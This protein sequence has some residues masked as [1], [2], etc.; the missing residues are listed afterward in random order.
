VNASSSTTNTPIASLG[1]DVGSLNCHITRGANTTVV[2]SLVAAGPDDVLVCGQHAARIAA[3]APERVIGDLLARL[4][5]PHMARVGGRRIAPEELLA[6]LIDDVVSRSAGSDNRRAVQ[7]GF[8]YPSRFAEHHVALV[9]RAARL[10]GLERVL[11]TPRP[12][13]IARQLHVGAMSPTSTL[14]VDVGAQACELSIVDQSAHGAGELREGARTLMGLGGNDIDRLILEWVDRQLDGALLSGAGDNDGNND[15]AAVAIAAALRD[16]RAAKE[17]MTEVSSDVITVMAGASRH[18][19]TLSRELLVA[20]TESYVACLGVNVNEMLGALR[21]NARVNSVVL[22]GGGSQLF[23]LADA[24]QAVANCDVFVADEPQLLASRGAALLSA[25]S[26]DSSGLASDQDNDD[27]GNGH[28]RDAAAR[29]T[30]RGSRHSRA[31]GAVSSRR[32][33]LGAI[34]GVGLVAA[35]WMATSAAA[36]HRNN[37]AAQDGAVT[38][39][40]SVAATSPTTGSPASTSATSVTTVAIGAATPIP[41]PVTPVTP[42][43]AQQVQIVLVPVP[44]PVPGPGQ[45]A[46]PPPPPAPPAPPTRPTTTRPTPGSVT[47]L[48]T[49]PTAPTTTAPTATPPTSAAPTTAPPTTAAPT[50]APPATAPATAP[51]TDPGTSPT[52]EPPSSSAPATTDAPSS[53]SASS[54][55]TEAPAESS[56]DPIPGG[57]TN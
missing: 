20:L 52:T 47:V 14:I 48:T 12:I 45:V 11:L 53:T 32:R 4:E 21:R 3:V 39:S 55:N 1:I 24:L 34:G 37:G 23:G 51:P 31:S 41:V 2:P 43:T 27:S 56:S 46:S 16:C 5:D 10:S 30:R 54:T 7:V 8:T 9:D 42:T 25:G 26:T 29:S 35:V 49:P 17:S 15:G 19:L 33:G 44:A 38:S 28:R 18:H 13:A 36:A 50:T 6:A 57:R 22:V 40:T